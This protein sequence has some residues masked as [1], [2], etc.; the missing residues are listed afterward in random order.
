MVIPLLLVTDLWAALPVQRHPLEIRS[1][2][3][4][5]L[6]RGAVELA[7]TQDEIRQGLMFRHELRR[8]QGMFFIL[9]S[10]GHQVFWMKNMRIP[11]DMLFV[12]ADGKVITIHQQVP[13][14]LSEAPRCPRY[15]SLGVVKAVLEVPAG[16]VSALGITPGDQI[17]YPPLWS[18]RP[19][20]EQVEPPLVKLPIE[21]YE[22]EI[23][24]PPTPLPQSAVALD[25]G[26]PFNTNGPIS[27]K[28]LVTKVDPSFHDQ[29]MPPVVNPVERPHPTPAPVNAL[30]SSASLPAPVNA[31]PSSAS[32][33]APVNDLPSSASLP[34]P[35]NA[36]PSSASLPAPVNALPS[37]GQPAAPIR[38]MVQP[39]QG[40]PHPL[41]MRQ[42][43]IERVASVKPVVR[44][45][46]IE[47]ASKKSV[48]M[49]ELPPIKRVEME[50]EPIWPASLVEHKRVPEPKHRSTY[51]AI[52]AKAVPRPHG[53]TPP[54]GKGKKPPLLAPR[55][56]KQQPE[57]N[58]QTQDF[59]YRGMP[60]LPFRSP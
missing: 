33:P 37:G 20:E 40:L 45:T 22:A 44:P 27:L 2:R 19:I 7:Q 23:F 13:P 56:V 38:I 50:Q 36:L 51:R 43:P 18:A 29:V 26:E 35:V 8:E 55:R 46:A 53:I 54:Y 6:W 47:Q 1:P 48:E 34:A 25:K 3:G 17:Q 9:P 15:P 42:Q 41:T 57:G 39:N 24:S 59:F 5:L 28:P 52:T 60:T 21:S 16:T 14:C 49:P 12:N 32:L 10:P 11:L 30:P 31:L 58:W 4:D